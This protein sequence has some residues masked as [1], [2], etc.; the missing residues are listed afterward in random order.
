MTS[1][2][3][4]QAFRI[5]QRMPTA[6]LPCRLVRP[7]QRNPHYVGRME[8]R[9]KLRQRLAPR[10]NGEKVQKWYSLCGL[11]GVGKT[12]TALNYVFEHMEDFQ[13]V[14]WAHTDTR[15]K[16]LESFAT[17]AVELG[18]MEEGDSNLTGRDLLKRWFEDTSK[19]LASYFDLAY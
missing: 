17:F 3:M 7:H 15:A 18:L 9:L 2:F 6:R 16:L 19:T 4:P 11:G 1:T 10:S 8:T 14:L 12:Q 5:S 13:A